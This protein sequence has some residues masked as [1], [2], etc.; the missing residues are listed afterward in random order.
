MK[1]FY[2]GALQIVRSWLAAF[3]RA[4]FEAKMER[5]HD[6]I[7]KRLLGTITYSEEQELRLIEWELTLQEQQESER[8]AALY[9]AD[10]LRIKELIQSA[11]GSAPLA[12]GHSETSAN[13]KGAN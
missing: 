8:I 5:F 4:R 1:R 3:R 10:A 6:L 11:H 9:R 2:V 13:E 12:S 7:D